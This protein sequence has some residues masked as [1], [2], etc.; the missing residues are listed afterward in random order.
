MAKKRAP[1]VILH[2]P[3]LSLLEHHLRLFVDFVVAVHLATK[4]L[5]PELELLALDAS[6]GPVVA[7]D[8][9]FA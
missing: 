8:V 2:D 6:L 7:D 4:S 9:V 5:N 3:E 1:V